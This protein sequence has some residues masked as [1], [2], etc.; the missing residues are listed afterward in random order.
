MAEYALD[1][2]RQQYCIARLLIPPMSET[3]VIRALK[4]HYHIRVDIARKIRA[5]SVSNM[6]DLVKFLFSIK[7]ER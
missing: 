6:K 4:G 1:Y 5:I 3:E 2:A 7:S